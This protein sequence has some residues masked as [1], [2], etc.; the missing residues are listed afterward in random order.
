MTIV[1]GF[2]DPA[3]PVDVRTDLSVVIE[4]IPGVLG[5]LRLGLGCSLDFYE[6]GIERRISLNP[7]SDKTLAECHCDLS[8][9][10]VPSQIEISKTELMRMF[11]NFVADFLKYTALLGSEALTSRA[12]TI[13]R[14]SSSH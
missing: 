4:Q 5:Q 9:T 10:P 6:Q 14:S 3:W 12:R 11:N 2:G 13:L 1:S 8:W 7:N